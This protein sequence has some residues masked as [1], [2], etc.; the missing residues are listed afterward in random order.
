MEQTEQPINN[1]VAPESNKL[2]RL[3]RKKWVLALIA[4]VFLLPLL[5][6]F[7]LP[8]SKEQ[9]NTDQPQPTTVTNPTKAIR[10]ELKKAIDEAKDSDKEY[11]DFQT[12][13][14]KDYPWIRK[15][16][17]TTE[18]YYIYFDLAKKSFVGR[19]YPTATDNVEQMKSEIINRLKT[20]KEITLANYKVEWIVIPQ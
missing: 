1:Y 17:L 5:F 2:K 8:L 4:V 7:I 13:Y 15:L 16:P 10:P 12:N 9:K 18:K 3:L 20:E 6:A 11:S 19:L 14:A